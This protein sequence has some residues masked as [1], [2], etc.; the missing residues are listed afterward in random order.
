[1]VRQQAFASYSI[2]SRESFLSNSWYFYEIAAQIG[3][4]TSVFPISR[5][6]H[7]TYF[8]S[9]SEWIIHFLSQLSILINTHSFKR[10]FSSHL[11]S[12][13]ILINRRISKGR[14]LKLCKHI[15]SSVC[16]VLIQKNCFFMA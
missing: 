9:I 6:F 8:S 2:V 7:N 15:F 4:E 3:V 16:C 14:N 5:L 1:M 10:N 12:Y 13:I 11:R